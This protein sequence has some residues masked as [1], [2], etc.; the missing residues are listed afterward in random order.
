MKIDYTFH[1]HTFRCGHAIGDIPDY[2]SRAINNGLKIY[3]VSDHVFLPGIH[4]TWVRGEYELLDQYIDV[5]KDTKAKY[6]K[7]IE[8]HLGFE[9]EYCEKFKDY[10]FSLLKEK[11]FDYL[12]CGQ[13]FYYDQEGVRHPYSSTYKKGIIRGIAEYR[14]D[15]IAAMKSGLFLYIAHPDLF[16]CSTT[17]VTPMYKKQ[18]KKII[19]AALKYDVALEI[20]VHGL[21]RN[22]HRKGKLFID[23]PCEYFWKEVAKTNVKVVVGYDFHYPEEIG[24]P[25]LAEKLEKFIKKCKIKLSDI[26]EIYQNYRNRI[27][28]L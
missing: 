25:K 7:D 21:L 4:E 15:I 23:Y 9:C 6:G 13:H 28:K 18:T 22:R 11:G 5:F 24:D 27:E 2:V 16:F 20:N 12:I 26:R 10:Y 14:R 17:K 8:M 1:S 19:E 3:G